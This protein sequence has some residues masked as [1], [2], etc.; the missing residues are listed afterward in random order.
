MQWST[1]DSETQRVRVP[2]GWF[3]KLTGFQP[4][5]YPDPETRWAAPVVTV[6]APTVTPIPTPVVTPVVSAP[7]ASTTPFT[8]KGAKVFDSKGVEFIA[9]GV[10]HS[11]SWGHHENNLKAIVEVAKSGANCI[12]LVFQEGMGYD[13]PAERR[14]AV[15]ESLRNKLV[16]IVGC[17]NATG[18]EDVASLT[19]CVDFWLLPDSVKLLKQYQDRIILNIAN[20]WGGWNNALWLS[21][22]SAAIK[23][24]RDAGVDC[25]IMV[26]GSGAHGQNPRTARDA[27]VQLLASDPKHNIVFSVHMYAF[28]K[29]PETA[30]D[31]AIGVGKW[32]DGGSQCP[33]LVSAEMKSLQA[34]GLAVI[35]GEICGPEFAELGFVPKTAL[36][37]LKTLGIGYVAWSWNQNGRPG[38]DMMLVGNAYAYNG[39]ADLSVAGK[40]FILDPDVGLK[41]TAK[42]ATI[43]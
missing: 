26:D 21:A 14:V 5:F 32:N 7:V 31:P 34:L 37:D 6:P 35:V 15:E 12:R 19:S 24:I 40:L 18:K 28:W 3:V 38:L 9:R 10:N 17:W 42:A 2:G 13:T 16:P 29:T 30:N 8:V 41:A 23:R 39:P 25:L 4:F 1:F 43:W 27:G 11:M 33:W 36:L 20:E 22:Y